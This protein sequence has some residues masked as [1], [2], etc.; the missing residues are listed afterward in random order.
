VN[1]HVNCKREHFES[2]EAQRAAMETT[3]GMLMGALDAG[4]ATQE[5]LER[6]VRMIGQRMNIGHVSVRE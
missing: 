6:V 3:V 4:R 1:L 2:V 5:Q